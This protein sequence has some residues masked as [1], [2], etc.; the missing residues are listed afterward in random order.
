MECR[1]NPGSV[2]GRQ[3]GVGYLFMLFVVFLLAL[4]LGKSM[5]VYLTSMQREREAQLAE[6][7]NAYRQAIRD[8]Y[9]SAPNGQHRYPQRLE[10][11]LKDTRHLVIRRYLRRLYLDPMTSQP[12]TP[13][14]APEG[15]VRGV[16]STSES[17]PMRT[18]VPAGVRVPKAGATS[19]AEW[20]FVYE[21]EPTRQTAQ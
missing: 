3:R 15:G 16:A 10:D 21:G 14:M 8:Y 11:L 13:L 7:G 2:P 18:L 4:G 5:D 19:Y 12:F 9:L 20:W 17:K 1:S 6:I